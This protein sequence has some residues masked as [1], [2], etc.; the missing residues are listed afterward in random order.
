[1]TILCFYIYV[2]TQF[3]YAISGLVQIFTLISVQ[4]AILM[5]FFVLLVYF[6]KVTGFTEK[7]TVCIL[8][9]SSMLVSL[10]TA[11]RIFLESKSKV[12]MYS[13]LTRVH[14]PVL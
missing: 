13:R 5:V 9:V 14:G 7:S 10:H 6:I 4:L 11:L 3:L 1:M 2:S 12:L 8:F